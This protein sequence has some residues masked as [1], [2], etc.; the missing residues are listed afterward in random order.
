M[1]DNGEEAIS[2]QIDCVGL[3]IW[4]NAQYTHLYNISLSRLSFHPIYLE[5]NFSCCHGT[6]H[7]VT[8]VAVRWKRE[9]KIAF[10]INRIIKYGWVLPFTQ[11]KYIMRNATDGLMKITKTW[12]FRRMSAGAFLGTKLEK[13]KVGRARCTAQ[14]H[15][16]THTNQNHFEILRTGKFDAW[17]GKKRTFPFFYL[18]TSLLSREIRRKIRK[19]FL[20]LN[21]DV[22]KI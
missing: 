14:T 10:V 17:R 11:C 6:F 13:E 7:R 9:R 20:P 8:K 5:R 3:S 19:L 15:T 12:K 1:G 22:E 4:A 18:K 16:H 2:F 21:F